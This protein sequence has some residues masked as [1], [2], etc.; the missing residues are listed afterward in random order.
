MTTTF[1]VNGAIA[2]LT[3][4]RPDARNAMTW[5]MYDAL[6]EA[7]DRVD[8]DAA[9]RVLILRGAGGKAFVSGTDISQ[10]QAFG[11]AG[12]SHAGPTNGLDFEPLLVRLT[13]GSWTRSARRASR[14]CCSPAE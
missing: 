1:D 2:M 14:I 12:A 8:D 10:F 5:A 6:V 11:A 9:I 3:F 4:S 7:C 13:A